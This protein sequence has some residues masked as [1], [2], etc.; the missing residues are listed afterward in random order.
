MYQNPYRISTICG[1]KMDGM[2]LVTTTPTS[3][4]PNL[5]HLSLALLAS[6]LYNILYIFSSP[7]CC[8]LISTTP[9]HFFAPTFWSFIPFLRQHWFWSIAIGQIVM[10][11]QWFEESGG[12]KCGNIQW[13][14]SDVSDCWLVIIIFLFSYS[15]L[16]VS[17]YLMYDVG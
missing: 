10:S 9:Q 3:P 2:R 12:T 7:S 15:T 5:P 11:R 14:S 8:L 17:L 6:T 16:F 13:A 1:G 4:N